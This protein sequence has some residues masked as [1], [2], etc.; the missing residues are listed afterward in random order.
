MDITVRS[1]SYFISKKT[2][3]QIGPCQDSL[4]LDD[5]IENRN[6][7]RGELKERSYGVLLN[8]L[9]I[10]EVDL[11]L[12]T[13][14]TEGSYEYLE[15]ISKEEGDTVAS[16]CELIVAKTTVVNPVWEKVLKVIDHVESFQINAFAL[17]FNIPE[18]EEQTMQNMRKLCYQKL[19]DRYSIVS[20]SP[21]KGITIEI[22]HHFY[23]SVLF[24]DSLKIK[25]ATEY[26]FQFKDRIKAFDIISFAKELLQNT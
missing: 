23:A 15:M 20:Y 11:D 4:T 17:E 2:S 3:V 18:K 6:Q 19:Q 12:D 24:E 5:L 7:I 16:I 13:E 25:L 22:S 1:I 21:E 10:S 9:P 14:S 26:D 8:L